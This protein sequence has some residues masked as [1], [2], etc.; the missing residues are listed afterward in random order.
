MRQPQLCGEVEFSAFAWRVAKPFV[1]AGQI[2]PI[3]ILDQKRF[4]NLPDIPTVGEAGYPDLETFGTN[5]IYFMAP[6]G[7]PKDRAQILEEALMK[8]LKDPEF[9]KWAQCQINRLAE[10]VFVLR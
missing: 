8:T 4:P 2:R 5:V 6:P 1:E 7:V 3:L 9:V 10:N